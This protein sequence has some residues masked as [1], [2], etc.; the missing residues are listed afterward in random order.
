MTTTATRYYDALPAILACH[1]AQIDADQEVRDAISAA[2]DADPRIAAIR[3]TVMAKV[4]AE[5][6]ASR[7]DW[8]A[9]ELLHANIIGAMRRANARRLAVRS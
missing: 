9:R 1:L 7:A 3:A 8:D 6:A 4:N 2:R 5:I